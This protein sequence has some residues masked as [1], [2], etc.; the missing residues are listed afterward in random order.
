MILDLE[1]IQLYR[2]K[3]LVTLL[4]ESSK[5][6]SKIGFDYVALSWTPAPGPVSTMQVNQDS[7]W[8]NFS[9]ILGAADSDLRN[10]RI[11]ALD[12]AIRQNRQNT[13]ACQT[14]R[15]QQVE[16]YRQIED[17]PETFCLI[18]AE[19]NLICDFDQPEWREFVS[20]PLCKERDR[21]LLLTAKAHSEV[22]CEQ[23]GVICR[24]F[25][26]VMTVYRRLHSLSGATATG[27]TETETDDSLS[28]REVE[29]LQWLALGKTLGEAAT[30]LGIS[31]RTLR[32]HVNN[33]RERLGV[34]TTVQAIV[35]AALA[36]GFD[37]NDARR[38][39]YAAC[40]SDMLKTA[41]KA[42]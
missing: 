26:T 36:Y 22:R 31:E 6:L 20:L 8:D 39:L 42:G 25:E 11:E 2:C 30:I 14:W 38:S 27:S 17:A 3:T 10:A 1:L 16:T 18:E 28:R 34:S 15:T 19:R 32:F 5:L 37:P 41:R 24:V 33:A 23:F 29:C 40:R 35:S 7:I 13:M 4:Q 12:R 21:T 9:E